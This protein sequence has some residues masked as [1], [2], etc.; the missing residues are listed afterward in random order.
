MSG[1]TR[2]IDSGAGKGTRFGTRRTLLRL[3]DYYDL[4]ADAREKP[5]L[6]AAIARITNHI[7]DHDYQLVDVDGRRTRWGFGDPTSSGRILMK[8]PRALHI[9][10]HLVH[11][12]HLA[13]RRRPR[14]VL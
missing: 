7:L 2:L 12:L 3:P 4:V 6:S 1:T 14:E 13:R 10:A 9:L 5:A 8:Q 11:A